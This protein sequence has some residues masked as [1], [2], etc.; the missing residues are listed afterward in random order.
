MNPI[1]IAIVSAFI[2]IVLG[3]S[4]FARINA[5][6]ERWADKELE[7][8]EKRK[9]VLNELEI[10]GIKSAEWVVRLSIELAVGKLNNFDKTPKQVNLELESK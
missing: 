1:A 8:R 2:R 5:A 3:S 9:G 6:V 7:G 4:L 10:I